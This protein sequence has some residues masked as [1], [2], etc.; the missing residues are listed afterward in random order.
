MAWHCAICYRWRFQ[1]PAERR[2]DS[3][4]PPKRCR[5]LKRYV[6][7][8]PCPE[9]NCRTL[10]CRAEYK[11]QSRD[12]LCQRQTRAD[13]KWQRFRRDTLSQ[14]FVCFEQSGRCW[15]FKPRHIFGTQ[16]SDSNISTERC[17]C[18]F[19]ASV[20]D[21]SVVTT[22]NNSSIG[23]TH[24][25]TKLCHRQFTLYEFEIWERTKE[26]TTK[27]IIQSFLFVLN[28]ISSND[29]Y[30]TDSVHYQFTSCIIT[31]D[32]IIVLTIYRI[33][34]TSFIRIAECIYNHWVINFFVY[35]I[36]T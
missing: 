18:L 17:R 32:T 12:P 13:H 36:L 9:K 28:H 26:L 2:R 27:S 20:L 3:R 1:R 35:A 7:Y 16:Q 23:H 6:R 8:W 24:P 11:C 10:G 34:S 15:W 22:D 5:L 29:W 33:V 14:M 19:C 4:H 25:Y 30:V 21:V 31:S